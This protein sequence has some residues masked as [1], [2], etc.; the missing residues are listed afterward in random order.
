MEVIKGPDFPTGG[1][2]V[3]TEGI[4]NAY[5]TGRGSIR[6][7]AKVEIE[8]SGRRERIVIREI[9][10]QVNK[11]RLLEEIAEFLKS[12]A[13]AT[14]REESAGEICESFWI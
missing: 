8:R 9:P 1:I 7:R 12:G 6:I 10:Y 4:K 3:G 2:I 13:Q 11:S 5:K 14:L